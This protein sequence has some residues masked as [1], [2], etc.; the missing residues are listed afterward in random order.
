MVA[1]GQVDVL[2]LV[3]QAVAALAAIVLFVGGLI[4]ACNRQR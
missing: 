1:S 4:V 3:V 2:D